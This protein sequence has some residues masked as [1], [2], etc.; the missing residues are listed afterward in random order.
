MEVLARRSR[1]GAAIAIAPTG[2]VDGATFLALFRRTLSYERLS[3]SMRGSCRLVEDAILE[4]CFQAF[5]DLANHFSAANPAAPLHLAELEVN[6]FAVAG[7]RIAP[8]DGVCSFRPAVPATVARPTAKIEQL[9][10]PR[11]IAVVGVSRSR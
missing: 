10:K 5:I 8:L 6:P 4:E 2:G 3:G 11:S 7:G 9:L 1:P